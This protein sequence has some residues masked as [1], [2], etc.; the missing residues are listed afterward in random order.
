MLPLAQDYGGG[1]LATASDRGT[2]VRVYDTGSGQKMQ[3]LVGVL[4]VNVGVLH[5]HFFVLP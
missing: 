3:E 1:L 4:S 5:F 2:I